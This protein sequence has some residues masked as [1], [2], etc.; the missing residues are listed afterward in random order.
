MLT[1]KVLYA[2]W[3]LLVSLS[4]VFFCFGLTKVSVNVELVPKQISN[5]VC[6]TKIYTQQQKYITTLTTI[7]KCPVQK[8]GQL[9][10]GWLGYNLKIT[11]SPPA[12]PAGVYFL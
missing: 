8:F 1:F 9:T 6:E 3:M 11:Y 4:V 2:S 7:G 12:R 10:E 5:T